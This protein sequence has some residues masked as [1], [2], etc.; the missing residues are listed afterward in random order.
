M[1]PTKRK[2]TNKIQQDFGPPVEV[3]TWPDEAKIASLMSNGFTYSEAIHM[4][5]RDYRRYAGIFAA[6][7]IP[8]EQREE[9]TRLATQADIDAEFGNC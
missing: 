7:S 2:Q 3:E 4:S 8:P 5:P 6:W 1:H 9:G